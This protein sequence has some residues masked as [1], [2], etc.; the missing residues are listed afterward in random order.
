[1]LRHWQPAQLAYGGRRGG[2]PLRGRLHHVGLKA[3]EKLKLRNLAN[4]DAFP[5]EWRLCQPALPAA[6]AW[7]SRRVLRTP[8]E[9]LFAAALASGGLDCDTLRSLGGADTCLDADGTLV[10][11]G[12]VLCLTVAPAGPEEDAGRAEGA[13]QHHLEETLACVAAVIMPGAGG[14]T[15]YAPKEERQGMLALLDEDAS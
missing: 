10:P 11:G 6:L 7:V 9:Q 5:C 15:V 2:S 1:M 4:A 12:A 14:L 13:P 3:F 8:S